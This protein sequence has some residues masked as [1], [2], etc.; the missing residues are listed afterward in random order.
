MTAVLSRRFFH[1]GTDQLPALHASVTLGVTVAAIV[2]GGVGA[3]VAWRS[4]R[5]LGGTRTTATALAAVAVVAAVSLVVLVAVGLR[6]FGMVHLAYLVLVVSVPIVG[7]TLGLR[8]ATTDTLARPWA[9]VAVL[10]ISPAAVG[11][12]ATHVEPYRLRVDRASL[13]VGPGR[14]GGDPIRIGVLADLQT[15]DI[16]AH[17]HAAVDLLL[18]EEPDL[19]L[20]AGDLFQ[21]SDAQFAAHEEELRELLGRLHAPAGVFVVRGD[22]DHDDRTDR[23]VKGTDIVIL[24]DEAADLTIGDR[25]VQLGGN[26]LAYHSPAA[27]E[28]RRD[29]AGGPEDGTIRILVAHRPDA[30][31]DLPTDSRVDLTVA[32]HTH[33]GQVVVPGFGPPMTLTSVPRRVA[34]GGLHEVAGNAIYVSNGVGMERAQAPQV[35]FFSPP[36]VG[37]VELT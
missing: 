13:A 3:W 30:V 33:G 12:Y 27:M 23:A 21:G 1:G 15:N 24:D 10:L 25:T 20:L 4:T 18:A 11:W 7:V 14:S 9:A 29:L 8:A 32:G 16:R 6:S 35:R 36:S 22:T 17:E 19:I 37:I 5:D 2:A 28:L 26:R 34:R 31:L